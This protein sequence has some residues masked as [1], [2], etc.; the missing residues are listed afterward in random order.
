MKRGEGLCVIPPACDIINNKDYRQQL[1][2]IHTGS[3]LV[4][5][6]SVRLVFGS[7]PRFLLQP[8]RSGAVWRETADQSD[9]RL[10]GR[11]LVQEVV[12]V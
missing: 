3:C 9:R 12:S 2:I 4:P 5:T 7:L 8:I 6:G 10:E 1:Y 11:R